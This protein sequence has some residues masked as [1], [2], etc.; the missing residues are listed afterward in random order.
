MRVL[1]HTIYFVFHIRL[2]NN[3]S[4]DARYFWCA[5]VRAHRM[6][7]PWWLMCLG[8]VDDLSFCGNNSVIFSGGNIDDFQ[9]R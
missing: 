7:L 6:H 1:K 2:Q 3:K 8:Q 5:L 9:P 4:K